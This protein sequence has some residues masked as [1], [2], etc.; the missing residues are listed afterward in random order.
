MVAIDQAVRFAFPTYD[1]IRLIVEK[2]AG[3]N[4]DASVSDQMSEVRAETER[5]ENEMRRLEAQAKVAQEM[6]IA[7]RIERAV[8]VQ[9]EEFYEYEG[10]GK[11]GAHG[12][13]EAR[14]ISIGASGS[15]KRVK[16]RIYRFT[17]HLN[18]EGTVA[19]APPNP[20]LDA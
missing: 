1:L 6:A 4:V 11:I 16:K 3:T 10:E 9:I 7:A 12:D 5:Q 2:V 13:A 17:G 18:E 19:V 15:G 20:S 14:T 8:E